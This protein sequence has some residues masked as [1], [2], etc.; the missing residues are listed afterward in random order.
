M[1]QYTTAY[2]KTLP[3]FVNPKIRVMHCE[4]GGRSSKTYSISQLNVNFGLVNTKKE[5]IVKVIGMSVPHLRDNIIND[6]RLILTDYG[7]NWQK[8]YNKTERKFR[9]NTTEYR[10]L[11]ADVDNVLGGQ[12]D[13][14]HVNEANVRVFN[15]QTIKQL[16]DRTDKKFIFDL[17]PK[18][19]FWFHQNMD[20]IVNDRYVKIHYTY[21]DNE[22]LP[23]GI[24]A[25]YENAKKGTWYYKV[26]VE[27]LE[28]SPEGVIFQNWETQNHFPTTFPYVY[29]IDFGSTDPESIVKVAYDKDT[30]TVYVQEMY[31]DKSINKGTQQIVN[32]AL[33]VR[34]K[35]K[36]WY[37]QKYSTPF[38]TYEY[39]PVFIPDPAGKDKI[40]DMRKKGLNCPKFNKPDL[41]WS[42]RKLQDANIVVC[43]DSFHLKEEL[44][45]YVWK[46]SV[47]QIPE[48]DN[49]H[50]ID[51]LRY[52]YYYL[53]S[54]GVGVNRNIY[55]RR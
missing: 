29:A 17:N 13:I 28:A 51:P 43:G 5:N 39:N 3:H 1:N 30:N 38:K 15:W 52:G 21:K 7:Y 48:D 53:I 46:D 20:E 54:K 55:D 23:E 49:N 25:N 2:Y 45:S 10:F 50:A 16:M 37:R 32:K 31:Y 22:Y 34:D 11:S 36:E 40:V 41:V 27:G 8:I 19:K 14:T 35:D 26:F 47:G 12:A 44:G 9:I 24:R 18:N 33:E 42:I 4:G 6:Y